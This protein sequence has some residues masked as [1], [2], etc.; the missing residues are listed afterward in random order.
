MGWV[1]DEIY[2]HAGYEHF[3]H[4]PSCAE[5]VGNFLGAH[6][7]FADDNLLPVELLGPREEPHPD[8]DVARDLEDHGNEIE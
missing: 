8:D 5:G 7:V 2:A 3:H 4:A 1:A 6:A